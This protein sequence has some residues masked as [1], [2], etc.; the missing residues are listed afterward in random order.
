MG[1]KARPRSEVPMS[2]TRILIAE[3]RLEALSMMVR[4][5]VVDE[6]LKTPNP[7]RA[8]D[9]L[10]KAAAGEVGHACDQR[11]QDALL[12]SGRR[13]FGV[14]EALVALVGEIGRDVNAELN[15]EPEEDEELPAA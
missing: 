3:A 2:L 7:K 15:G 1:D 5:I 13:A 11:R 4:R 14:A 12:E 8:M 10:R 6:I 9:K